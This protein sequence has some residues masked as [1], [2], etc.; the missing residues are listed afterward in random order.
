MDAAEGDAAEAQAANEGAGV[1]TRPGGGM[2][3]PACRTPLHE[4]NAGGADGCTL[5][6]CARCGGVWFD[7]GE[8]DQLHTLRD[9]EREQKVI[10]KPT[11]WGQWC[12]QFFLGLPVEFNLP[13]R[14]FPVVTVAL[15][16]LCGIIYLVELAVGED[17]WLRFGTRPDLLWQGV[18]LYTLVTSGFLHAGVLHLVGNMYFLYVLGDNVEDAL[19]RWAYLFFYLTCGAAADL[20]HS[21]VFYSTNAPLVGASGAISGVMAAYLLLYPKARLTF[22]LVFWQFKLSAAWWIGIYFGIQAAAAAIAVNQ[23]GAG[24]AYFGHIGGF[25]AGLLLVWPF[26]AMLIQRHPWLRVLH[27]WKEKPAPAAA[28]T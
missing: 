13:P 9:W 19:G 18:G 10:A 7:S 17:A 20:L 3:C 14:R 2:L 28:A 23:G 26:R 16:A 22:M 11:T 12:F 27:T 25:V 15:V 4:I 24:V 5:D 8:W 1:Q 6:Q 21:A